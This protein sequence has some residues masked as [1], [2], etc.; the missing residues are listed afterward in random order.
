MGRRTG[1]VDGRGRLTALVALDGSAVGE[2]ESPG[3]EFRLHMPLGPQ[4]GL[5]DLF[6]LQS[7]ADVRQRRADGAA[8]LSDLMAREAGEFCGAED[9]NPAAGVAVLAGIGDQRSDKLSVIIDW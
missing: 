5:G 8:A 3:D 2:A 6:C 9:R 1:H 7:F 4:Q